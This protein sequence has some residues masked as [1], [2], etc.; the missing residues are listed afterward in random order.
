MGPRPSA[1]EELRIKAGDH[2]LESLESGR[3]EDALNTASD[4]QSS[5]LSQANPSTG[6][7]RSEL[8]AAVEKSRNLQNALHKC[9]SQLQEAELDIE[10][11]LDGKSAAKPRRPQNGISAK[12]SLKARISVSFCEDHHVEHVDEHKNHGD[13][14]EYYDTSS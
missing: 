4:Q 1:L 13:D 2:L 11:L 8:R 5:A 6:S 7:L 9:K 14:S 3:L 10:A 12:P